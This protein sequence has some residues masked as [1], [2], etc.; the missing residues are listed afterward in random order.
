[1]RSQGQADATATGKQL[2]AALAFK[3]P[4]SGKPELVLPDSNMVFVFLDIEPQTTLHPEYWLGWAETI[5]AFVV[6]KTTDAGTLDLV[7]PFRPCLYGVVREDPVDPNSLFPA[8]SPGPWPEIAGAFADPTSTRIRGRHACH[9]LATPWPFQAFNVSGAIAATEA[10]VQAKFPTYGVLSQG[11][12]EPFGPPASVV[13]W[14]YRI[15]IGMDAAGNFFDIQAD[16]GHALAFAIDLDV[17][18][19]TPFEGKP[20]TDFM[21]RRP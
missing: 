6:F 19:A 1:V 5:S 18:T 14:Q 7:Q 16:P 8:D 10:Q 21:L 13:M 15:N 4:A 11:G 17:T 3:D 9:A 20:I 12:T 2:A